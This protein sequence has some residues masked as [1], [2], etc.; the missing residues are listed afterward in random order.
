M[1]TA[2]RRTR[3]RPS[4]R[5]VACPVARDQFGCGPSCGHRGRSPR[6]ATPR[7]GSSERQDGALVSTIFTRSSTRRPAPCRA[8]RRRRPRRRP[9]GP[10]GRSDCCGCR[11]RHAAPRWHDFVPELVVGDLN[12]L[13]VGE[14]R[15]PAASLRLRLR[16]RRRLLVRP[17]S[18]SVLLR[19][20]VVLER[21]ADA[22]QLIVHRP[23]CATPTSSLTTPSG[24]GTSAGLDERPCRASS[25]AA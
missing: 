20:Q 14:C 2:L 15:A 23:A 6:A 13:G 22:L 5:R 3:G 16:P 18:S 7:R 25:R 12:V 9:C 11:P 4:P 1:L 17:I 8:A 10:A 24:A 19:G 21:R